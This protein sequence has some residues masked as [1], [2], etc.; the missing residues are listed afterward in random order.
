M[1]EGT[2]LTYVGAPI[3]DLEGREWVAEMRF[4]L[5]PMKRESIRLI[6]DLMLAVVVGSVL[7]SAAVF[8]LVHAYLVIPLRKATRAI[9]RHDPQTEMVKMPKF[10]SEEMTALA[11]AVE[12]A[13][14]AHHGAA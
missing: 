6:V 3:R 8:W 14:R 7:F 11:R 9:E 13:C 5:A 2:D 4:D 12:D 10:E 1:L